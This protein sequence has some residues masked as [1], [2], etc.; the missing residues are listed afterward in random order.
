MATRAIFI[1]GC[2]TYGITPQNLRDMG[3]TRNAVGSSVESNVHGADESVRIR[4]LNDYVR[5][6][7]RLVT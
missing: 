1:C 4:D 7:V 2:V 3:R 6:L 5:F